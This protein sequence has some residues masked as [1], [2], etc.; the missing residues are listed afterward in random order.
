MKSYAI[1]IRETLEKIVCV[2]AENLEEAVD[3][4]ATAYRNVEII[5]EPEDITDTEYIPHTF[6]FDSECG[7]IDED[8]M[9][10]YKDCQWIGE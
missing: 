8:E 4:V 3:K 9:D 2:E 10:Y 5:I 1:I 7:V 6:S